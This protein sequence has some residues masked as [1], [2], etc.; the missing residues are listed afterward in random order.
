MA[1]PSV[2]LADKGNATLNNGDC[3]RLRWFRSIFDERG[4]DERVSHRGNGNR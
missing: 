1:V 3:C 2:P 4:Q